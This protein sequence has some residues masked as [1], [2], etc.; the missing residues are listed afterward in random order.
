MSDSLVIIPTYN[1]KE[2]IEKIIRKVFSLSKK[3]HV[4]IID[5]GSPDGTASIVKSMLAEFPMQLFIEERQGKL[6]LGT[7]Y[8]HGFRWGIKNKYDY[9]FEMDA[10]FSHNPDDLIRLYQAC[11]EKHADVAIGSRYIKG[12]KIKNWP[13]DRIMMSYF[14]SLYVRLVLWISVRDTTAGFKCYRRI[15]LEK[16]D[17]NNIK[18]VGYAFQIE[19]K[20]TAWRLGLKI[21]EVP[22]TFVDR[23][24]GYS[25]MS[26]GIFKEAFWGVILMRFKKIKA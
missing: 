7:A 1:E 10:D 26:K 17:L 4:L 19:M 13:L 6:G 3:F 25:K 16:I 21:I 2:N 14:A 18:F 8:I 20:Y 12:G 15:A 22:I 24:E 9:M 11:S 5:D 23:K